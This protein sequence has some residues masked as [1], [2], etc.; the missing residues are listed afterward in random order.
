METDGRIMEISWTVDYRLWT[1]D[2]TWARLSQDLERCGAGRRREGGSDIVMEDGRAGGGPRSRLAVIMAL[3]TG[4]VSWLELLW[5]DLSLT[6]WTTLAR[7]LWS[8]STWDW[9]IPQV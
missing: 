3:P 7:F 8:C 1:D 5:R 4:G 2:R 9:R 6:N